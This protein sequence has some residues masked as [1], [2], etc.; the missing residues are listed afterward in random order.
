MTLICILGGSV[1]L[2]LGA[3]NLVQAF[4][5]ETGSGSF[6]L[7]AAGIN[8]TVCVISLLSSF[9]FLT[10]TAAW[11]LRLEEASRAGEALQRALEQ[12]E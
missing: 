2:A 10:Y 9:W 11:D 12:G 3:V 7:L 8:L 1:F 4:T 6:S 5:G